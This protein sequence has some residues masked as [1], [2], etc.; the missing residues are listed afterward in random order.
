[1]QFTL[2]GALAVAAVALTVPTLAAAALAPDFGTGDT[3]ASVKATTAKFS[4]LAVAKRAG[5]GL[6][7]DKRGIACIAMPAMPGM[8]MAG[9]MG[10]HY[11][12]SRLVGDGVID[13]ERPEAL[14]YE[15]L[16]GG[17]LR[18][19]AVEYVVIKAAWD[20]AH[21]SAPSLFGHRFNETPAGNRYGLP[22][23]Y[24]LHAWLFKHNPSGE[25]AM[26]NPTVS[27]AG[28]TR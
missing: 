5:Y 18:L 14:V 21:A 7:K 15:P 12:N 6:L 28:A 2:R 8:A 22:A 26:W 27:C 4:S 25:F 3:P 11:A 13:A 23:F 24:S 10:F 19:A 20:K 1:M 17:K 16:A 9:A